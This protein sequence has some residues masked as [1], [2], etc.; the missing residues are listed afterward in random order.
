[1]ASGQLRPVVHGHLY[2][3]V[4][5]VAA[6]FFLSAERPPTTDTSIKRLSAAQMVCGPAGVLPV[7]FIGSHPSSRTCP[8][9]S[10]TRV[11]QVGKRPVYYHVGIY[12]DDNFGVHA[13]S[14]E[15]RSVGR[16]YDLSLT[17]ADMLE[18]LIQGFAI[19]VRMPDLLDEVGHHALSYMRLEQMVV[20]LEY[21]RL[22]HLVYY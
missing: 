4:E 10:T 5:E 18:P 15:N 2:L 11:R 16:N 8:C 1:M 22:D 12:I 3:P 21:V 13:R 6:N 9:Y 7:S 17:M 20:H 19:L 14:N